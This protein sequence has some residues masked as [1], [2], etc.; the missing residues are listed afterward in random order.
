MHSALEM[1]AGKLNKGLE[2]LKILNGEQMIL[3]GREASKKQAEAE[4]R[5]IRVPL[6]ALL[7]AAGAVCLAPECALGSPSAALSEVWSEADGLSLKY[8]TNHDE[9]LGGKGSE[10]SL[11]S[12]KQEQKHGEAEAG[13]EAEEAPAG[14]QGEPSAGEQQQQQSHGSEEGA[15]EQGADSSSRQL[16][17]IPIGAK[18]RQSAGASKQFEE[19]SGDERPESSARGAK[20]EEEEGRSAD[21]EIP[22]PTRQSVVTKSS[23]AGAGPARAESESSNEA[24]SDGRAD[25]E[26]EEVGGNNSVTQAAAAAA[27]ESPLP[28]DAPGSYGNARFRQPG[29]LFKEAV[30]MVGEQ[31][32]ESPRASG[33]ADEAALSSGNTDDSS[34][35]DEGRASDEAGQQPGFFGH[36]TAA[37]D[38]ADEEAGGTRPHG[39]FLDVAASRAPLASSNKESLARQQQQQQQASS[40][41]R[42]PQASSGQQQQPQKPPPQA[43]KQLAYFRGVDQSSGPQQQRPFQQVVEQESIESPDSVRDNFISPGHYPGSMAHLTQAASEVQ[44]T[45]EAA[46][47]AQGAGRPEKAA[48]ATSVSETSAAEATSIGSSQPKEEAA[49]ASDTPAQ[50]Q[51]QAVGVQEAASSAQAMVVVVTPEPAAQAQEQQIAAPSLL[52]DQSTSTTMAPMAA[53]AEQAAGSTQTP[54]SLKRFKFRRF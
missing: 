48:E 8:S 24:E 4:W 2:T 19:S 25:E 27:D 42:R 28:A 31:R 23:R 49:R 39:A 12:N 29:R 50:Q 47:K 38:E 40:S 35:A 6:L 51:Q 32:D 15:G 13:A 54:A 1:A 36:T 52:G 21:E 34:E 45:A 37:L 7:L 14:Q 22:K 17:K 44:K 5:R 10:L 43:Y 20:E 9:L 30:R 26:E 3:R 16:D 11:S 53:G 18:L 41:A 33:E 46:Q